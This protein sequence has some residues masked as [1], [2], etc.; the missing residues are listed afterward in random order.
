MQNNPN[1]PNPSISEITNLIEWENSTFLSE[2]ELSFLRDFEKE[3]TITIATPKKIVDPVKTIDSAPKIDSIPQIISYQEDTEMNSVILELKQLKSQNF[4]F[5]DLLHKIMSNLQTC[6]TDLSEL[7]LTKNNLIEKI[8]S[9]YLES[10]EIIEQQKNLLDFST[11]IKTNLLY[12]TELKRIEQDIDHIHLNLSTKEAFEGNL[13]R[14]LSEIMDGIYFFE[15]K[16]NYKNSKGFLENYNKLKKRLL[17]VIKTLLLKILNKEF[18]D[19]STNLHKLQINNFFNNYAQNST[20]NLFFIVFYPEFR[21]FFPG[22]LTKELERNEINENFVKINEILRNLLQFMFEVSKNDFD[23]NDVLI[24]CFESY[25]PYYRTNILLL[26]CEKLNKLLQ[27]Q[28]MKSPHLL[29]TFLL[30][31]YETSFYEYTYYLF[32]FNFNK[33]CEK[34]KII[35]FMHSFSEKFYEFI[36]PFV[37]KENLLLNI[38]EN[39]DILNLF[40]AN[41]K[42]HLEI[43]LDSPGINQFLKPIPSKDYFLENF[44]QILQ[45]DLL[46][47]IKQDLMQK[48]VFLIQSFIQEKIV[49]FDLKTYLTHTKL[50]KIPIES[51]QLKR[52]DIFPVVVLT[53]E[54]IKNL[55]DRMEKT[56]LQEIIYEV[57]NSTLN[58]IFTVAEAFEGK[59]DSFLFLMKHLLLL[60]Q[61]LAE[62]GIEILVKE[63]KLDFS[64]TKNTLFELISGNYNE[65][66]KNKD[67][68]W[69]FLGF[70]SRGMPKVNEYTIDVKKNLTEQINNINNRFLKDMSF[71]ISKNICDFLRKYHYLKNL[72]KHVNNNEVNLKKDLDQL[73]NKEYIKKIYNV[74]LEHFLET[75]QEIVAK[76]N[77]YLDEELFGRVSKYVDAI[78]ENVILLLYQFY[79]IAAENTNN[80]DYKT[81]KFMEIDEIR[82]ELKN[83]IVFIY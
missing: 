35:G 82:K 61:I 12:Y 59:F 72:L 27:K 25:Y 13:Q 42:Q 66:N 37:I 49:N 56:I 38:Y 43:F 65:I 3:S 53:I 41:I 63:Q 10:S 8:N 20:R 39:I 33:D 30:F 40:Q 57:I 31:S 28:P 36:R 50:K 29:E 15:M 34:A 16:Q 22:D 58:M 64:E 9:L 47:K 71:I 23:I 48:L 5:S 60:N 14:Y 45:N 17:I 32:L 62:V 2:D 19:I 4:L 1:T 79:I 68:S 44:I 11:I 6:E 76:S 54:L 69:N 80:E 46:L 7:S 78:I 24:D 55:K 73:L 51:N 18:T 52:N 26:F 77:N 74:F 67:S 81:F 21:T 83:K 70:L 75:I